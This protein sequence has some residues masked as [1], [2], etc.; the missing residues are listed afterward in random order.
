MNDL[1]VKSV[2]LMGDTIMAAQDN[3]GNIWAGVSFFCKALGMTKGQKDRQIQNIQCDE[4]LKRG[5]SKFEAGVFDPNNET[6]SLRLDYIP[7]WLTK[8][9]ITNKM[10]KEHPELADKLLNY[11]LKAKDIL[12]EAFMHN[13]NTMPQTTD[14]KIALLAQGHME[15]V[16][17]VDNLEHRFNQLQQDMPI[18]GEECTDI[19]AAVAEKVNECLGGKES[20]AYQNKK[21]HRKLYRD[22][23]SQTNRQFGVRTYK[24]IK[25]SQLNDY[26]ISVEKYSTPIGIQNDIDMCNAQQSF[27]LQE[28]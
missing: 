1:V 18:F 19:N 23:Y 6:V 25:R 12:A 28:D 27:D 7:L 16:E 9:Q 5:A 4:I 10:K 15:L 8:I 11:Q 2:D 17:K 24:S 3:V 22:I 26:I 14:G 20:N 21:L 13:Q